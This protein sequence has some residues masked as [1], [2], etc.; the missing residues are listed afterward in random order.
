VLRNLTQ[1]K[2]NLLIGRNKLSALNVSKN[3]ALQTAVDRRNLE[4]A[5]SALIDSV[6]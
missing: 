2:N 1:L 6:E 3:I 5:T 4:T